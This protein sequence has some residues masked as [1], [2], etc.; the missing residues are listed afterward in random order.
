MSKKKFS[1]KDL[2]SQ[3]K[4]CPELAHDFSKK[5]VYE[6]IKRYLLYVGYKLSEPA[7][8]D[9][10]KVLPD[11]YAKREEPDKTFEIVVM[12]KHSLQEIIDEMEDLDSIKSRLGK[13]V[14]YTIAIPPVHEHFVINF[15]LEDNYKWYKKLQKEQYMIWICNPEEKISWCAFGSPTDRKIL[16]FFKFKDFTNLYFHIPNYVEAAQSRDGYWKH[17]IDL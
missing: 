3:L 6:E 10:F 12:I 8:K 16:D 13:H 4:D 11:V 14:N 2:I 17:E 15:L 9:D 5:E 1:S 7:S